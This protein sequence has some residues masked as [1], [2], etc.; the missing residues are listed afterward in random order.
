MVQNIAALHLGLRDLQVRA[1]CKDVGRSFGIKVH[2]D[3]HEMATYALSKLLRRPIKYVADRVE[4]FNTDIHARDHRC[5]GRIGVKRDGTITAFEIDDLTGIGPYSMYP[6][7]SVVEANQAICLTGG[8][9]ANQTIAPGPGSCSRTRTYEPV[10]RGWPS[11]RL[12]GDRGA[13]RPGGGKVG[14]DPVEIRR[15]T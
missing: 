14:I 9:Y 15:R 8:Q 13:G 5:R 1:L 12:C 7:T 4:S 6:R 11:H 2:M 3:A 10:P